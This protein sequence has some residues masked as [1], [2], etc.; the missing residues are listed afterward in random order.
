[1][2]I[3]FLSR[4][5]CFAWTAY[6]FIGLNIVYNISRNALKSL[7]NILASFGTCLIKDHV[8]LFGYLLPHFRWYHFLICQVAF[9][10]NK[11][12]LDSW[13][14]MLINLIKPVC[15]IIKC[16]LLCT[17]I[18][19]DNTLCTSVVC[20]CNCSKSFLASCIP[21]LHFNIFAV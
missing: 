17:I 14:S 19:Q 5:L 8:M 11:D 21:N 10:T 4:I 7:V 1:M 3:R 20:L 18:C 16:M 15:N 6:L 2:A 12:F 9:V 13:C